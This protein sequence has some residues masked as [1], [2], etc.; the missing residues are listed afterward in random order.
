MQ[1]WEAL[2]NDDISNN[3][4][5]WVCH[6]SECSDN[7]KRVKAWAV[8]TK[9]AKSL[10][11]QNT[12]EGAWEK[13]ASRMEGSPGNCLGGHWV[14]KPCK[15][16]KR[17]RLSLTLLLSQSNE[18]WSFVSG[19]S[20]AKGISRQMAGV[21]CPAMLWGVTSQVY[22]SSMNMWVCLGLKTTQTF[23]N[24]WGKCRRT[25]GRTIGM[26]IGIL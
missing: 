23:S 25:E 2:V 17:K 24:T 19:L 21:W 1:I 22:W 3:E 8:Q 15:L 7:E 16:T 12:D 5:G 20:S 11:E 13:A 10:K 9:D 6:L 4:S 26:N 14:I 18:D